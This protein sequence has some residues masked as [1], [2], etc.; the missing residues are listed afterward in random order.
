MKNV[1]SVSGLLIIALLMVLCLIIQPVAA[2]VAGTVPAAATR[3]SQAISL[4]SISPM[5]TEVGK[6]SWSI[7]GLG[8]MASTGHIQ[9]EK[10][11]GA[12]V[13][14]AYMASATQYGAAQ[15]QI[16]P[17]EIKIDGAD[18]T[19]TSSVPNALSTYNYWGDVTSLVKPKL[20]A[21][22]AGTVDFTITEVRP[23]DV[24]GEMLVVIFNDP[25]QT[26][27]NTIVLMFGAQQQSGDTF[28]IGLAEPIDLSD[29]NLALEF[30]LASTYSYQGSG[31]YSIINVNGARLST[32]AGGQDDGSQPDECT[33]NGCLFTVGGVGDLT[34]NPANPMQ[35]PIAVGN[36]PAY[37]YDDELYNL[38]PFV[39]DGDNLITVFTQNPSYDDNLMFAGLFIKSATAVVGKGIVLSPVSATNNLG[40]S[41]T[42]T[43][44]V[45]DD[46][47]V[48][49]EGVLVTFTITAGPNMGMTGTDTTNANGQATWSY[50][51]SAVGTDTIVASIVDQA[52]TITSNEATKSWE[53]GDLI[54]EFPTL[55]VPIAGLLGFVLI[56]YSFRKK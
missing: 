15:K 10:P 53:G 34:T 9:V 16:A 36:T 48:P 11:A 39:D 35:T 44:K 52:A 32:A 3:E 7:D 21:A 54:P 49:V 22:P 38:L 20:D 30:S 24:D 6:I 23:T 31:Q 13:R 40:E 25:A 33:T 4:D 26:T 45:Q 42:L 8:T 47:G 37:R 50:T 1:K 14:K 56:T 17:G 46:N 43:A 55:L 51:S 5:V 18:V 2:D 41:H 27:D 12:T 28:S 29:P 19:F